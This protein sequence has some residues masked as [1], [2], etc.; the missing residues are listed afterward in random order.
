M[1]INSVFN[2][3]RLLI[4]AHPYNQFKANFNTFDW[5]SFFVIFSDLNFA[6]HV[7]LGW[8]LTPATAPKDIFGRMLG[9][10]SNETTLVYWRKLNGKLNRICTHWHW[11]IYTIR[12]SLTLGPEVQSRKGTESCLIYT[13][14][15]LLSTRDK[16]S[17]IECR[18]KTLGDRVIWK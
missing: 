13:Q 16:R 18:K 17:P 8:V 14:I 7:L 3:Y 5:L 2:I 6:N 1:E 12:A 11:G 4:S 15:V 10:Y 9:K